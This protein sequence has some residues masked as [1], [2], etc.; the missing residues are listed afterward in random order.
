MIGLA[1]K[2]KAGGYVDVIGIL[3]TIDEQIATLKQ[4]R[5]VLTAGAK[6]GRGRPK[7]VGTVAKPAKKKRNL[8]PEGRRRI[9]EGQRRRWAAKKKASGK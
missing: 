5:A 2:E 7:G 6:R 8:S 3:A 4:A 1:A 9:A